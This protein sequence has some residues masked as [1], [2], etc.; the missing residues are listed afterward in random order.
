MWGKGNN[1]NRIGRY[2]CNMQFTKCCFNILAHLSRQKERKEGERKEKMKEDNWR[3]RLLET[4]TASCTL[5]DT[6]YGSWH[7]S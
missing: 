3:Y 7:V 4:N 6:T 1:S 2:L 5:V